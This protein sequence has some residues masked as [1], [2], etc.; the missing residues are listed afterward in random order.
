M[1]F[2]RLRGA[3]HGVPKRKGVR[4]RYSDDVVVV[5]EYE[6]G[7]NPQPQEAAAT[8]CS[9]MGAV[10]VARGTYG[11]DGAKGRPQL[12]AEKPSA[13]PVDMPVADSGGV[14]SHSSTAPC[15]GCMNLV[16]SGGVMSPSPA[17]ARLK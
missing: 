6:Q 16:A 4:V 2:L 14:L 7:G 1:R 17:G 12:E 13:S 10:C 15:G 9:Q 5:G 11:G 3:D 8:T